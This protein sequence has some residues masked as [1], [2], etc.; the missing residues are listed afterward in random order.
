MPI[1]ILHV[2][3]SFGIGGM[4][5]IICSI[6]K[7]T[8]SLYDHCIMSFDGKKESYDWIDNRGV[9]IKFLSKEYRRRVF[10]KK[11]YDSLKI[12]NP[13]LLMSYNWGAT[14]AIWLSRILGL[15][16][17]IH[18]EHGFNIDEYGKKNLKRNII[19]FFLYRMSRTIIVPSHRLKDYM[20]ETYNL[21]NGKVTFIPNGI[22]TEIY[23]PNDSDKKIKRNELGLTDKDFVVGFVGR[24]DPIKNFDLLLDVFS[25]CYNE[26]KKF[27]LL[28]VGDGEERSYIENSCYR[29]NLINNVI[30]VG[31]KNNIISYVRAF[32]AL[33]MTSYS[34]QM[35]MSIIES[36]SIGVPVVSSDVGEIPNIID[37]EENG[38][39]FNLQDKTMNIA[40]LLFFLKERENRQSMGM[41]A[42]SKII[43]EFQEKNMLLKYKEVIETTLS[44]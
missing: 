27:K 12:I 2:V 32:D 38:F 17:I 13:D 3:P 22:D 43:S 1:K 10:F 15:D 41:R 14:D 25:Y 36:M 35:P 28:I 23:S 11:L 16:R 29:K 21:E 44:N 30:M 39:L 7:N 24:L 26:D 20:L 5:R 42:R 9:E 18:S 8:S 37:H 31:E 4:E 19:R 40:R 33:L 34:E 6:I